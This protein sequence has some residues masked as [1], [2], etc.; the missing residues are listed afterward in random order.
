MN[1]VLARLGA[2]WGG[3]PLPLRVLGLLALGLLGATVLRFLVTSLLHLVRFD[4]MSERTGI[5]DFLRKGN[6]KY[7][8]SRL[9]G[10]LLYWLVVLFTLLRVLA[11]IDYGTYLELTGRLA[12]ALPSLVAGLMI[13]VIGGL[14]V[15][16]FANF[17]LTIALNAS[18]PNARLFSRAVKYLGYAVVAS[19]AVEQVGLGQSIVQFIFEILLGAAAFGTALAFGLGCKDLARDAMQRFLRNLREKERGGKGPDLEG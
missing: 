3:A 11:L 10:A 18:F 1:E 16:F 4:R 12:R 9:V 14:L 8:A 2:L 19:A 17:L 13:L 6:A 7:T 15:S 5:A